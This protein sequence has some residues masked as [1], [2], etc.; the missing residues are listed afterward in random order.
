VQGGGNGKEEKFGATFQALVVRSSVS[1]FYGGKSHQARCMTAPTFCWE[2]E[3]FL[4]A[5][6][7]ISHHHL[8]EDTI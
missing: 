7:G 8:I 3:A 2:W 6:V 5:K 4:E 1:V